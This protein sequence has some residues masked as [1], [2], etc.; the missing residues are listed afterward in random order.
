MNANGQATS[1][2]LPFTSLLSSDLSSDKIFL[3]E[4][5]CWR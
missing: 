2:S 4:A 1:K 5:G 3:L